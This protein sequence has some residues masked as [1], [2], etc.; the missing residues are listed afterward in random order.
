MFRETERAAKSPAASI[1]SPVSFPPLSWSLMSSTSVSASHPQHPSLS[2][3]PPIYFFSYSFLRAALREDAWFMKLYFYRLLRRKRGEKQRQRE[4][5]REREKERD[6]WRG[7]VWRAS[8]R[9]R[10]TGECGGD[11]HHPATPRLEMKKGSRLRQKYDGSDQEWRRYTAEYM[12]CVLLHTHS[13]VLSYKSNITYLFSHFLSVT[14]FSS[15][16]FLSSAPLCTKITSKLLL[17]W[18]NKD[19]N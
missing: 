14:H 19:T 17:H 4:G 13:W 7:R 1:Y 5:E 10:R 8:P 11:I 12:S 16:P 3:I 9:G 18:G 2:F 6:E 15:A